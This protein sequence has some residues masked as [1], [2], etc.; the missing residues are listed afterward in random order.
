M[1]VFRLKK[2]SYQCNTHT[3][4]STDMFIHTHSHIYA[5]NLHT[6]TRI[7]GVCPLSCLGGGEK[8]GVAYAAIKCELVI[9]I[10]Q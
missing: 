10:D 8:T 1:S 2:I 3:S 5:P 6:P 9:N 7:Q 4:S